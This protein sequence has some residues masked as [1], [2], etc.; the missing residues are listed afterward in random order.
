MCGLW[1]RLMVVARGSLYPCSQKTLIARWRPPIQCSVW[2]FSTGT[3]SLILEIKTMVSTLFIGMCSS[4]FPAQNSKSE[5]TGIRRSLRVSSTKV[6]INQGHHVLIT[7]PGDSNAGGEPACTLI[8]TLLNRLCSTKDYY[9]LHGASVRCLDYIPAREYA[10]SSLY[11]L[12]LYC[13][14]IMHGEPSSYVHV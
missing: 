1:G 7:C 13:W 14:R 4:S 6:T 5:T 11:Y 2:Y 8:P 10:L 12:R 3:S 9:G